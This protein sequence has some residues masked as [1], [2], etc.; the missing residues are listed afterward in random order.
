MQTENQEKAVSSKGSRRKFLQKASTG[1]VIASL[2]TRSVWASNGGILNSI[3]AS[4]HASGWTSRQLALV[5]P[6]KWKNIKNHD[7]SVYY[8][9]KKLSFK[10]VFKTTPIGQSQDYTFYEILK[11]PGSGRNKLGGSNNINYYLVQ[12]Y[13]NAQYS[14]R[15]FGGETI[16]FQVVRILPTGFGNSNAPFADL[17]AFADYLM[18]LVNSYGASSVAKSLETLLNDN[19]V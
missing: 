11:N 13:L 18:S 17:S 1:V 6:G 12:T 9:I 19:H 4:T 10:S 2:P 14:G 3:Q 8:A 5:S 15:T 7:K 16:Y